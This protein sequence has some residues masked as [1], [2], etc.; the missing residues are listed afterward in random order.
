MAYCRVN[1]FSEICQKNQRGR[2]LAK[3]V[4]S[5]GYVE[6]KFTV[7]PIAATVAL[8]LESVPEICSYRIINA[9]DNSMWKKQ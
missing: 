9:V 2:F 1:L 4:Q 6:N 8:A 3:R 7:W 5:N